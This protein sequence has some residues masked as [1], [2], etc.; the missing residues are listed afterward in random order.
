MN[1]VQ[2]R[3]G[4]QSKPCAIIDY[5][6]GK[7]AID[8]SD[9]MA[10]YHRALRR[11]VKWYRKVAFELILNTTVVNALYLHNAI[12]KITKNHSIQRKFGRISFN[13]KN[14]CRKI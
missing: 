9:Q 8:L 7:S 1:E 6:S 5:N 10:S 4:I 12:S 11:S 2:T 3:R 13:Q 14:K